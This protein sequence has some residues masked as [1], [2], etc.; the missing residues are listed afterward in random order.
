[1]DAMTLY[2]LMQ[3]NHKVPGDVFADGLPAAAA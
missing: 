3:Q 2:G 1:M